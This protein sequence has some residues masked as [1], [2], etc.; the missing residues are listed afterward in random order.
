MALIECRECSN[1]VSSEAAA[2]PRCGCP[3]K[4]ANTNESSTP[5][6]SPVVSTRASDTESAKPKMTAESSTQQSQ[7]V[8]PKGAAPDSNAPLLRRPGILVT[9]SLIDLHGR[10]YSVPQLN[11]IKVD[12]TAHPGAVG[13][14]FLGILLCLGGGFVLFIDLVVLVIR[15][16]N[17]IRN[18]GPEAIVALV[19]L[20]IIIFGIMTWMKIGKL[21]PWAVLRFE[22]SSGDVKALSAA[23]KEVEEVAAAIR[24]AMAQR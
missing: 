23:R 6:S 8:P 12:P 5:L 22:M 10:S 24:T 11:S 9:R 13:G 3:S 16:N 14:V 17:G 18:H 7:T 2:C 21:P 15:D 19:G 4:P 1:L 20:A